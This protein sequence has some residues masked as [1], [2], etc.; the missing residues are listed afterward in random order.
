MQTGLK[1][2]LK[3]N[4][5]LQHGD[6]WPLLQ[7]HSCFWLLCVQGKGKR[8]RKCALHVA[9]LS[10]PHISGVQ[11]WHVLLKDLTVLPAHE[12]LSGNVMNQGVPQYVILVTLFCVIIY[13]T[14]VLQTFINDCFWPHCICQLQSSTF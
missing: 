13:I 11:V 2:C 1:S 7:V 5:E 14:Q 10:E 12:S 9:L 3:T 6:C 8:E 4:S